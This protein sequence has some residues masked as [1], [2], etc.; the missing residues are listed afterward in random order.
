MFGH[1]ILSICFFFL[2]WSWFG[3][4]GWSLQACLQCSLSLLR[5]SEM[6]LDSPTSLCL[7][8]FFFF[9][10]SILW[11][12]CRCSNL[13]VQK[14][15]VF[16]VEKDDCQRVFHSMLYTRPWPT[17]YE[18]TILYSVGQTHSK[19][20]GFTDKLLWLTVIDYHS[21]SE[22]PSFTVHLWL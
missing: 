6:R 9:W 11:L 14:T 4:S 17:N 7:F 3:L 18:A 21:Q 22:T 15:G 19:Y 10:L 1:C 12:G 13:Q 5:E 8:F 16:P 2:R 20:H